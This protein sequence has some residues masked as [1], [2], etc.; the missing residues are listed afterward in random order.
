M[1]LCSSSLT[2]FHISFPF[3]FFFS[4]SSGLKN[5]DSIT[6][7]IMYVILICK[8]Y[9]DNKYDKSCLLSYIAATPNKR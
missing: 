6:F 7:Q 5:P 1:G 2:Y 4:I 8:C 3:K 9:F